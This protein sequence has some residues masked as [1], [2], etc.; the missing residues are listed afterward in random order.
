M[1][2]QRPGWHLAMLDADRRLSGQLGVALTPV[3]RSENGGLPV[4]LVRG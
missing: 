3:W 1:R 2:E 4:E